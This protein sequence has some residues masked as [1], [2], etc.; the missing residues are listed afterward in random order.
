MSAE[1]ARPRILGHCPIAEEWPIHRREVQHIMAQVNTMNLMMQTVL[2]N[3]KHLA[4]LDDV[5][6][7]IKEIARS[8]REVVGV[9]KQ[10]KEDMVG[11]ATGRDQIPTK[12]AHLMF[13]AFGFVII[14]LLIVIVFLLTG[15][16]FGWIKGLH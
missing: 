13:R 14:A 2:E 15:E 7:G 4:R 3:S 12:T 16:Q 11:P 8:N 6:I 1:P 10:L 9:I 5:S